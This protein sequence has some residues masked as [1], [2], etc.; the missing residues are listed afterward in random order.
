MLQ[1]LVRGPDEDR[2]PYIDAQIAIIYELRF[3]KKYHAVF[4]A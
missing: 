2:K 1:G 4:S 3:M